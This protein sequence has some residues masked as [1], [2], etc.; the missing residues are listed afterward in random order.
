MVRIYLDHAATTPLRPEVAEVMSRAWSR[1]SGNPSSPHSEGR[2]ARRLL[3]DA[4]EAVGRALATPA[5]WVVFTRG[6]TESDNLAI[7]GRAH[8]EPLRPL[9]I[10]ALEHAA[11]R[12]PARAL[13]ATGTPV[14]ILPVHPDG[15]VDAE[16][17]AVLLEADTL[18]AVVSV[19]AVNSET[20]VMPG[21]GPVLAACTA[22]DVPV[23]VDAVQ[24]AGRTPIP[25]PGPG[26]PA[27]LTLSGHK[28][29]GPAGTGVL[30]RDPDLPLEPL[31]RGG[32]QEGA[33]RPG[34]ED[35]PGAVGFAEA[36][37]LAL[38]EEPREGARLMGLRERLEEGLLAAVPALR[39]HGAGAPRAPHITSLGLPGVPRDL[40][41]GA[42]DLEGVAASAGSACR[43]GSPEPSPVV[44]ALHGPEAARAAPLRLS[45]GR[46]TDGAA[47]DE[48]LDRIILV[49]RR[50][51]G[52]R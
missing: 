31:L 5:S 27:L 11:V 29:G 30:V 45:L 46:T 28:L 43:S 38:A 37:R 49:L 6:G 19:Q 39:L 13:A 1:G 26:G 41:P 3:E 4:R 20:G 22:R 7:R 18:P 48:A 42:L 16:A 2:E 24:A 40:L 14:A 52:D 8:A 23:H 34:T 10:S 51:L 44:E 25:V 32:R 21:L 9:A 33:V 12:E 36:L 35:V 47:V 50:A 17:L 15:T